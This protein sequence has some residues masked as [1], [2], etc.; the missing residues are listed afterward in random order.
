MRGRFVAGMSIAVNSIWK[1]ANNNNIETDLENIQD[2]AE[3]LIFNMLFIRSCES[4]RVLPL[5]QAYIPVSLHNLLGKLRDFQT[6]E[7]SFS[8]TTKLRLKSLFKCALAE[9]GFEIFDYL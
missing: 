7:E 8:E 1:L 5:H 2:I 4:R 3:S 9:D 6:T